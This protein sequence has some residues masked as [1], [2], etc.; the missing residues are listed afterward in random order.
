MLVRFFLVGLFVLG[1]VLGSDI[2]HVTIAILAKDKAG[3]LPLY[4]NC[5][6]AQTWPKNKTYLYIRTNNNTDNTAEI[7]KSWVDKVAFQYAG[8]Y[9]DTSDLQE[10]VQKYDNHEWNGARCKLLAGLRQHSV[11][12]A[13]A[14]RSH[15]FV[16]DCDNFIKPNTLQNLVDTNLPVVA[17]LLTRGDI[18]A[19]ANYHAA[20]DQN[21]YYESTPLYSQILKCEIQGLVQVPVVHCTY[22]VRYEYLPCVIY[23]DHTYRYEY[24][25]FSHRL[26]N[27]GVP[28]YL[29]NR[30]CYG[31]ISFASKLD[32]LVCEPWIQEVYDWLSL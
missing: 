26:R 24:V 32:D 16:A 4:L 21:G 19:Y 23:D 20:V 22:F 3:V 1:N 6:E 31:Y 12:W 27:Q 11:C 14:R 13:F 8:I 25:I 29:D 5:I 10:Q 2:D 17:P 18:S 9:F 15:Y 7:L 30:E 28:Q